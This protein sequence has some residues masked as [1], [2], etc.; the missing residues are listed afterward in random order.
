MAE[1]LQK[2]DELFAR[3]GLNR[4]QFEKSVEAHNDQA[5]LARIHSLRT[6]DCDRRSQ[7]GPRTQPEIGKTRCLQII[8]HYIELHRRMQQEDVRGFPP[9]VLMAGIEDAVQARFGV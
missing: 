7:A 9:E 2:S 6:F 3:R 5:L 1:V 4:Q 8:D